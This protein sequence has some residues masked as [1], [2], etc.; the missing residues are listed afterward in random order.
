MKS[1]YQFLLPAVL[2]FVC[3]ISCNESSKDIENE[4]EPSVVS[5]FYFIRHA[6]KDR[7][8][9]SNTDPELNQDGLGRAI[10]WA[11]V[12]DPVML[13]A[14]YSTNYER[15][16]MTAAPTSVKK[17]I[18]IEYF[19]YATLNI[20]TFLENNKGRNV[21]V[22]GHSNTTPAMA[23]QVL[24]EEYYQ[25]MADDDNSS[26]YVVRIIGDEA[27]SFVLNMN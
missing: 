21:L 9:S 5:T 22:V 23:N 27:T 25:P 19:D 2:L 7:T 4:E 8:D 11:E 17:E 24:G 26:L 3:T 10:K 16:S 20:A 12:F 14:I 13:D 1:F 6:E 15:T 18:V